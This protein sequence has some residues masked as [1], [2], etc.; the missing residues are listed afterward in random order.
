MAQFPLCFHDCYF[1]SD[2]DLMNDLCDYFKLNI[3]AAELESNSV[4]DV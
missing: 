2:N 3:A 1:A 4:E